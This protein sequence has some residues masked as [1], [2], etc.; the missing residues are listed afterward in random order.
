MDDAFDTVDS[1]YYETVSNLDLDRISSTIS[2][3]KGNHCSLVNSIRGKDGRAIICEIKFASPSTGKIDGRFDQVSQIAREMEAG[4]A[5]GLSVLTE[6][7]N[8]SGSL[9]NLRIARAATGLPVI[10]KD[11]VVSEKQILAARAFGASAILFIHEVFSEGFSRQDLT[12]HNAIKKARENNLEVIVETHSKEGLINVAKLDCDIIGI[13]NR[14][15]KTFKTT[16]STTLDLLCD[17]PTDNGSLRDRLIMSES[18]FETPAD[19]FNLIQNLKD[20]HAPVPRAFL[21]GTSIMKS[22]DIRGK[23]SELATES[24]VRR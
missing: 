17:S 14:D 16:I 20:R 6:P 4:G 11:I 18:G 8:F 3:Q 5:A 23:V 19:I 22:P 15:L 24:K 9:T 10:M 1:G 21:I 13:N 7:K 2:N 12:L